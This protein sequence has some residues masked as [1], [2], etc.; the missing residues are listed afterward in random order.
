M[1][2]QSGINFIQSSFD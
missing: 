2:F 1:V